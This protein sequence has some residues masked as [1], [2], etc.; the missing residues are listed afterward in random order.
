MRT[1]RIFNPAQAD[2]Q[3]KPKPPAPPKPQ[4]PDDR[5]RILP[6]DYSKLN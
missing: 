1:V 2:V 6:S 5:V 3:A 4:S